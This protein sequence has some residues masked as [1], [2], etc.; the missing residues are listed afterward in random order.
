MSNLPEEERIPF[1]K[2]FAINY[3]HT[4]SIYC[5]KPIEVIDERSQELMRL[6]TKN[7]AKN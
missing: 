1:L 4:Y 6:L 5:I 2:Q 3:L 7:N